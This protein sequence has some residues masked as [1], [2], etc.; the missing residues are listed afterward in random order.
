MNVLENLENLVENLAGKIEAIIDDREEVLSEISGLRKRLME[1]D[2]EAVKAAQDMRAELEAARME[3]LRFEQEWI[4]ME[5]KL[6][7]L[8]DRLTALVG[9]GG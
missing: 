2:K 9:D 8:N 1:R 7:D 6:Q 5:A 3:A 4:G